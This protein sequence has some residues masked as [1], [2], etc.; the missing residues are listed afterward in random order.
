MKTKGLWIGLIVV[1]IV[2]ISGAAEQEELG[3]TFDF[4]YT[5]KWLSKGVEAYGSKGGLFETID[6]DFYGSGFGLKTT[7]RHSTSGGF[8][9][10][11]RID[12]RPYYSGQAYEG[13]T[14]ATTYNISVGYEYYYGLAREDAGTTYEWIFAFSWPNLLREG[15]KP[16]Y[17]AHYEYPAGSNYANRKV[18]GWVHRFLL[19][20]DIFVPDLP[21]KLNLC[22]EVAYYDGLGN[23][24]HDWAY[25]TAGLKT[26]FDL[27]DDLCF[28]PG[29]YHQVTMDRN[30]SKHEDITYTMMSMRY[31]F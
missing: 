23:K 26:R 25:F 7:H 14:Y 29:V 31:A 21:N 16:G 9:D 19:G 5:S 1:M 10:S 30:I 20:Y 27:S 13:Q 17:I 22:T 18:T 24:V 8:V 2:G 4:T 6:V 3:V 15:L 28:I 11:Q 12:F